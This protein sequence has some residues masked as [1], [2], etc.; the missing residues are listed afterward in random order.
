MMYRKKFWLQ[1]RIFFPVIDVFNPDS[2]VITTWFQ[3]SHLHHLFSEARVFNDHW[4]V[5]RLHSRGGKWILGMICMCR[6]HFFRKPT[7]IYLWQNFIPSY[8]DQVDSYPVL[9]VMLTPT[10][11]NL[12]TITEELSDC[13]EG[14]TY[15]IFSKVINK[16]LKKIIL[17]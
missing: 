4:N 11:W 13:Q 14:Y 5:S 6:P 12:E 17:K 9:W 8:M 15:H 1:F 3:W 16:N 2:A 10:T 7:H